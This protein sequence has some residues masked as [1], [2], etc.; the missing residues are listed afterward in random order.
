LPACLNFAR[1]FFDGA[2]LFIV[3]LAPTLPCAGNRKELPKTD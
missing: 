1:K 2:N 3:A